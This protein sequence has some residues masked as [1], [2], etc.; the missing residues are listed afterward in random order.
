[1]LN[2]FSPQVQGYRKGGVDVYYKQKQEQDDACFFFTM[3][4]EVLKFPEAPDCSSTVTH[5]CSRCKNELHLFQCYYIC[6]MKSSRL[7]DVM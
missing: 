7:S 4:G 3:E 6:Y 1:M 5:C 2:K